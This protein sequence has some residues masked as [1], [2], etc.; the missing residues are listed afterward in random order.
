MGALFAAAS[1]GSVLG[2][3]LGGVIAAK[4]G[5]IAA[6]GVVGVPG[7]VLALLY[8]L[9]R[10]YKTVAL[11]PKRNQV[12]QPVGGTLKNVFGTL[13]RT[14]TMW[15]TCMGQ[16]LQVVVV[17]AIWSW[18]PSFLNRFHGVAPA[19]AGKQAA[20]VILASAVGAFLWGL[21]IDRLSIRRP[22]HKLSL[23]SVLCLVSMA[24]LMYAFDGPL[25]GPAQLNL[26]IVG[27]FFM[28]CSIG[29]VVGVVLDVT[30]PGI[31]STGG[32]VL[33]VFQNLLGLAVGPF[34]VGALSDWWG[35]REALAVVPLFS[36]PAAFCFMM[37]AR[38]Y[39]AD[40]ARVSGIALNVDQSTTA[41]AA[42]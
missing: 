27:G 18:L 32:A 11:T 41:L 28:S 39:V 22:R 31:R 24:I 29:V 3:V 37:A 21:A 42:A 9:V 33:A 14:P 16:T 34:L 13:A 25:V 23:L 40:A 15:W 10:D 2:V 5:W 1:L 35:L 30:H 19:Q 4:W 20:L 38:S 26:I 6:F 7:L 12:T 8:L 36:I 17:A